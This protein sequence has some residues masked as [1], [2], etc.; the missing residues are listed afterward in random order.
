MKK[1]LLSLSLIISITS[2]PVLTLSCS[3]EV[4]HIFE[5]EVE[6]LNMA[7][8]E[9]QIREPR[10]KDLVTDYIDEVVS[11]FENWSKDLIY[12]THYEIIATNKEAEFTVGDQ[13]YI[14]PVKDNDKIYGKIIN[15]ATNLISLSELDEELNLIKPLPGEDKNTF[16]KILIEFLEAK[17]RGIKLKTDYEI[18]YNMKNDLSFSKGD[19]IT[20]SSLPKSRIVRGAS[21]VQ[22][23]IFDINTINYEKSIPRINEKIVDV[24]TRLEKVIQTNVFDAKKGEDYTFEFPSGSNSLRE[25]DKVK[26][27]AKKDSRILTGEDVEFVVQTYNIKDLKETIESFDFNFKTNQEL[28]LNQIETAILSEVPQ[29]KRG[30]DYTLVSNTDFQYF[31]PT[32]TVELQIIPGNYYLIGE[33]LTFEVPKLDLQV[34]ENDISNIEI[35]L[36]VTTIQEFQEEVNLTLDLL[37]SDIDIKDQVEIKTENLETTFNGNSSVEII[38]A[39][40]SF[41]FSPKSKSIVKKMDYIKLDEVKD[42]LAP[43]LNIYAGAT[44]QSIIDLIKDL[45][46]TDFRLSVLKEGVD[47]ELTTSSR[48]DFL[49]YTDSVCLSVIQNSNLLKGGEIVFDVNEL[50]IEG[51]KSELD[52]LEINSQNSHL[53]NQILINSCLHEMVPFMSE[54]E[55]YKIFIYEGNNSDRYF[56]KCSIIFFSGKWLSKETTIDLSIN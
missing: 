5:D 23:N 1:L 22:I 55:D 21:V 52:K 36:G 25:G 34:I 45:L 32:D 33:K 37:S 8:I 30:F 35:Q 3:K 4:K 15:K 54:Y 10:P 13:V 12:K 11:I 47:F 19:S 49:Y 46:L 9:T 14:K 18:I 44:S 26:I 41:F 16:D 43:T 42:F 2:S 38:P 48:N 17:I 39:D 6:M 29:A 53:E 51:I 40:N 50:E 31:M 27:V 56:Q 20:V 24:E 28:F 7:D